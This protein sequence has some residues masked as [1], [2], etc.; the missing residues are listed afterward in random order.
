MT[1]T[2][3]LVG[4]VLVTLSEHAYG[5]LWLGRSGSQARI[6]TTDERGALILPV[7][8]VDGKDEAGAPT[9]VPWTAIYAVK[10]R[11]APSQG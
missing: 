5:A 11:P 6:L 4:D 3:L 8:I 7:F 2:E 10:Q 9:F 1:M